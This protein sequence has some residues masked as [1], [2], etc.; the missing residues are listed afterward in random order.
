LSV[1]KTD[2][3]NRGTGRDKADRVARPVVHGCTPFVVR[4]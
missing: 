3:G 1:R 4:S 2:M